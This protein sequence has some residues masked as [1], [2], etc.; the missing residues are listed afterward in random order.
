MHVADD[1]ERAVVV[2]AVGPQADA[3][4]RRVVDLVGRAQHVDVTEAL[5]LEVADRLAQQA[6]LLADGVGAD[7][8]V[9]AG[10]GALEA[11]LG[12]DVE[13]DRHG[14]HVVLTGEADQRCSGVAL[15]AGRVDDG[16]PAR[17]EALAGDVAKDVEGGGGGH[18][19]VLVVGDEQAAE[20]G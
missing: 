14:Q 10:A 19:I 12:R 1:V 13:H 5:A 2:A 20:I 3:L 15:H 9:G 6:A 18:L 4:D 11:Q 16:E 7:A 17:L 8:A